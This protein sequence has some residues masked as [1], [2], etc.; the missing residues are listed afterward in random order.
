VVGFLIQ[1]HASPGHL[2]TGPFEFRTKMSRF[3]MAKTRPFYY[4]ENI[5]M[6]FF[7]YKTV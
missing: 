3:R 6:T 1:F 5:F 7:L 4:K 2:K